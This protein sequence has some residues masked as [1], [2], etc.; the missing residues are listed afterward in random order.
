MALVILRTLFKL[1][2]DEYFVEF[3][4]CGGL[5][6]LEQLQFSQHEA[7][8]KAANNIIEKYFGGEEIEQSNEEQLESGDAN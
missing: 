5:D 1:E 3:E 8:Y 6:N 4:S 2:V 7:I